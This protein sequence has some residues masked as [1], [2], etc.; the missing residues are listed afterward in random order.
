M[1]SNSKT[2]EKW[3]LTRINYWSVNFTY[4]L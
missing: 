3:F 2:S 4:C 1:N